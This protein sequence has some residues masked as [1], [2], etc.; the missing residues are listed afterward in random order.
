MSDNDF[1]HLTQ[2]R[3]SKNVE[4]LKQK[5]AYHYEY[6]DS[7]KRFREKKLADKE[8]FYSSVK[9]GTTTDNGEKLDGHIKD[10]NYLTCKKFWDEFNMK[11]M[12]DY[13]AHYF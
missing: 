9:N 3:G 4:L 12:R 5:G 10:K 1:K 8:D 7:F 11:N 2:E 6:M 13:H